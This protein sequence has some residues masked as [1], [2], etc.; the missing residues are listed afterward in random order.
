[1][2]LMKENKKIEKL[3]IIGY[4]ANED[5]EIELG[6]WV[7]T[8]VG[9]SYIGKSWILRALRWVAL[10]KPAGTV[11]VDEKTGEKRIS[12][13][14]WDSE[15]ARVR[16]FVDGRSIVRTRSKSIN[17]YKLSGRK[18]PYIAFGN[19]VPEE[20]A[21]IL[22]LKNINFQGQH[23]TKDNRIPFWFCET[24][25]E[26]SRQ[27]N[28]IVNLK[29]IDSTLANIAAEMRKV[30]TVIEITEEALE[31]AVKKRRELDYVRGLNQ[32][33]KNVEKLQSQ[34]DEDL[35][36]RSLLGQKIILVQNY[37][38]MQEKAREQATEGLRVVRLI[39]ECTEIADSVEKL[40]KLL[41]SSKALQKV[42]K[43]RPPS[44]LPLE[45]FRK[46]AEQITE[47]C[48]RL[49]LLIESVKD[50][51]QEKCRAQET[52]KV[53]TKELERIS[54]GRCPLCGARLKRS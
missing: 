49:D 21:R 9:R 41:E 4:G 20:I 53:L 44:I 47:R 50:R 13:I 18:Q 8:I 5:I 34:C 10:N 24:A 28:S 22:N 25:G 27:L 40:S 35:R 1:M 52:S 30:N 38:V 51:R 2:F 37:R 42:I 36:K 17:T 32:D 45:R 31:E 19:D 48:V 11:Y 6:P 46:D 23:S 7:T 33:L 54:Q 29:L 16:L 3:R 26:V 15:K 39:D 43:A 12:C 14:N